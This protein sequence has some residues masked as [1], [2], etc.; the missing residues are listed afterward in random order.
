[1]E[2]MATGL[3]VVAVDACALGEL[4]RPGRNGFLARPGQAA[5][6]A[7][8]LGLLCSDPGLRARMSAASL[9]IISAHERHRLLAEWES[10]YRMLTLAGAGER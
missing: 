2:A 7:A 6:V 1:M 3:P 9:E 4:V 10:L 8:Y 5:E